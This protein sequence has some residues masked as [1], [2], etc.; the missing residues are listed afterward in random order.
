[1]SSGGQIVGGIVGAVVG[2][3]VGGPAG[4]LQGAAL[5]AGIGGYLDPPKGPTVEG[6]RL[7]DQSVQTSTYGAFIP[8]VRGTVG[9]SGNLIWLENNK[10]KETVTKEE[11]GGGKGGGGSS[12]TIRTYSYS[13]TFAVGICEG[14]IAGVRRIWCGDKLLYNV[15]STDPETIAASNANAQGWRLYLGTDDQL[16]NSRYEAD[17]GVGNAPAFRGMAYIVF[18]DF[19]LGDYGN[20][21]QAAQFKF[22]VVTDQFTDGVHKI[23]D[24][25]LVHPSTVPGALPPSVMQP[26][27]AQGQLVAFYPNWS[28]SYASTG[29]FRVEVLGGRTIRTFV[30]TASNGAPLPG[31][32]KEPV[33]LWSRRIFFATGVSSS[34][35]DYYSLAYNHQANQSDCV[36]AY[37]RE[38]LWSLRLST[39]VVYR[40]PP[41]GA[42]VDQ[43]IVQSP[44]IAG[45]MAV[46]CNSSHVFVTTQT[47]IYRLD[48][49]LNII[50]SATLS[51][52]STD[53]YIQAD[54]SFVYHFHQSLRIID[55]Q[56]LEIVDEIYVEGGNTRLLYCFGVSNGLLGKLMTVGVNKGTL[57]QI[58]R[59]TPGLVPLSTIF[60]EECARTGVLQATDIDVSLLTDGVK[61]YRISGGTI[62]AALEP[63]QGAFPFDV[64]PS[65]YK[66]KAVP[67]GQSS[68]MSIPMADLVPQGGGSDSRV[69]LC[70]REMDSQLPFRVNIKY[71]DRAREYAISEQYAERLNTNTINRVDRELPLVMDANQAAGVCE[72]L[73][74]L[75]WL[76]REEYVF[77]LP[78]RYRELEPADVV[79]IQGDDAVYELRLTEANQAANGVMECRA[80]PN[81]AALYSPAAQGG[82]APGP[83]GTV[84]ARGPSFFIPLDIPVV[85]EGVQNQ[86]GFIGAVAGNTE[87]WPGALLVRS[88]DQ[89]QTW[90]NL[91]AFTGQ[92]AIGSCLN[93]LPVCSG[94]MVDERSLRVVLGAGELFSITRDQMFAGKNYAA[95]GVNGRWE[96]IRFQNAALQADGSYLLG[97]FIRGDRGT[98]WATGLHQLGDYFVLL[99]DPDIAFMGAPVSFIGAGL[100]YRAV[101]AG[102]AMVSAAT[103]DF[104][105]AGV[106]LECLS[107]VSALG[108]RDAAG[109]FTG[110]FSRRSRLGNNWWATGIPSPVGEVSESWEID[111]MSGS[112]VKRTITAST[113][114]FTYSAA[115]QSTDFGAAQAAI[116]FRIYQLSG[117]VGRGYPLEVTL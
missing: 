115:T 55:A 30:Q 88:V 2:F 86:P 20:T 35:G 24:E 80:K 92:A 26:V 67:R 104:T 62:R 56:S 93:V 110:R 82:E 14:T 94:V 17:V 16:P 45:A 112:T 96:I 77:Q 32:A 41:F 50:E 44:I 54:D 7:N 72:V 43:T 42:G 57:W 59:G 48:Y 1:M 65:G 38:Y 117:T 46:D 91:Q 75:P 13:A 114:Q 108:T 97:A 109:N 98:E 8:R 103:V 28:N 73:L 27:G 79:T 85:D 5:G 64:I 74:F 76:E 49:D 69:L 102:A 71:L 22:E 19:E 29:Y 81:R 113:P 90:A 21:L 89:G 68:V 99:D 95:Y 33:F 101:T 58:N 37:T 53:A 111:V 63:L 6:P 66:V 51:L 52:P 60:V 105:Y 87:S 31:V 4:A 106:N 116:T 18:Y 9:L 78:P 10:L 40:V 15:G 70:S 39:G 3:Y 23:L 11:S 61:G 100:K 25:D 36:Y 84:S 47:A 107:P 12:Q 34:N 83:D